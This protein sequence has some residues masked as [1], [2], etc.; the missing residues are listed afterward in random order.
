M[1]HFF[2]WWST[3][4]REVLAIE[5]GFRLEEAKEAKEDKEAK[6]VIITGRFDRVEKSEDGVRVID[7]KTGSIRSQKDVDE[8]L[9]LSIYAIAA[10]QVFD[11]QCTD[12]VL[13][14]LH[15]DGITEVRTMRSQQQLAE[16]QEIIRFASEG[17]EAAQ[18]DPQPSE[19][20]CARCPYKGIC[21]A[22]LVVDKG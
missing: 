18:F 13:L 14:F 19:T 20:K 7:Y 5:K 8:D 1:Q 21:D 10:E 9:Q 6:D 15:E 4:E 16:A 2:D 11:L 22:A 17:I 3:E 12:L